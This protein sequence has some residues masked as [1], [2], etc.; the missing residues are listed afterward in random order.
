MVIDVYWNNRPQ[1]DEWRQW[2]ALKRVAPTDA[3][4]L[5][6]P[7]HVLES[8]ALLGTCPH[9]E[10]IVNADEDSIYSRWDKNSSWVHEVSAWAKRNDKALARITSHGQ[11][12]YGLQ[13]TERTHTVAALN[14]LL[15][16]LG[17]EVEH[18]GQINRV[19]QYRKRT[20][21]DV[22][23][24]IK[25]AEEKGSHTGRLERQAYRLENLP[26]IAEA[27]KTQAMEIT[28]RAAVGWI[29][30]I[31]RL[32]APA[33]NFSEDTSI[34]TEPLCTP[35]EAPHDTPFTPG[36][37]VKKAGKRGWKGAVE[38]LSGTSQAL[39]KWFGDAE[40]SLVNL[41]DLEI[42]T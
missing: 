11:R 21:Q 1:F 41:R 34:S 31:E 22:E 20:A 30:L 37:W 23:A 17:I 40:S 27:A 42:A 24:L 16:E 5:P 8:V 18:D 29:A 35:Q 4:E 33:Q 12:I 15:G 39:V 28:D 38:A 9:F 36:A 26:E 7:A 3:P 6:V 32:S 25:K 10:G 19:H 2:A 14:K 13:F